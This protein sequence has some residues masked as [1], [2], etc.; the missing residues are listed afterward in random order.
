M[1]NHIQHIHHLR[2]NL[3]RQGSIAAVLLMATA[4]HAAVALATFPIPVHVENENKGLF[5]ELTREVARQTGTDININV[6]PP[7]RAVH[8]FFDGSQAALFPA[9]DVTFAPG[10]PITRTAES[11]DCKEDFV[12]TKKGNP[13]LKTLDDLKGKHVGITRGY[14]YA[15]EVTDNKEMVIETA[16]SDET[17]IRKLIA[18]HLDAFVL[19][20]KTG[21]KAFEELGL[22]A[23]MQYA[24]KEPVSR[25]DV[26]YAFQ[27][28]PDGKALAAKFSHALAQMKASGRYQQITR[29]ITIGK[30]CPKNTAR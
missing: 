13:M 25:Q 18:G 11:I 21:V 28:T 7:L 10:Q 9:L 24:P 1:L 26:Y 30:G 17:N 5:I 4:A 23:Q 12:F 8:G 15:R 20:E 6:L 2:H 29:G 27:N 3:T 16:T 19:D 22:A 14:P